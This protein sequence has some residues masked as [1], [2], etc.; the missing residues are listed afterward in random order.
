[1]LRDVVLSAVVVVSCEK[2]DVV[3]M[4][5]VSVSASDSVLELEG[6]TVKLIV[7]CVVDVV[8]DAVVDVGVD[9]VVDVAV[10]AVVDILAVDVVVSEDVTEEVGITV[11]NI[12]VIETAELDE[13]V[14]CDCERVDVCCGG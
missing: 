4:V 3:E 1:M 7:I 13:R 9:A 12:K 14:G 8:V 5:S 2:F 11:G 10:G 6:G